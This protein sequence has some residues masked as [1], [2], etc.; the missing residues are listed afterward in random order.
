MVEKNKN[1][2]YSCW[3]M[4]IA[5]TPDCSENQPLREL[6]SLYHPVIVGTR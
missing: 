1:K 2:R 3:L 5:A 6:V 4:R